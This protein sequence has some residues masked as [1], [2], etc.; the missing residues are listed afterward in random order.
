MFAALYGALF[1]FVTTPFHWA[2]GVAREVADRMDREMEQRAEEEL[3]PGRPLAELIRA[4]R[5]AGGWGAA[6]R[7]L[8]GQPEPVEAPTAPE[9]ENLN[10]EEKK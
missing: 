8:R 7:A 9:R 3:Y 10:G 4:Q 6:L 2:D 5:T 1:Q